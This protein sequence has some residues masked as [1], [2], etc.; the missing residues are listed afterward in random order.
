M[1]NARNPQ[2]RP[3]WRDAVFYEI[4]VRSFADANGDGVG[5][6]A[7]IR[8]RLDHLVDLGVDALWLTPFYPSPMA[9]HGYDV[10]D[11]RNVD[12]L[13]G[14]LTGFDAL[15]TDAHDKGL[16]L[17]VDVVPNHSSNAHPWF[18]Q[19]LAE[20]PRSAA[21]DRYLFRDGRGRKGSDPPNNWDSVFG[22]SAWT[23]VGDGQWYLHLFAPEQPDLNWRHPDV[24]ADYEQTLRFWLD[25]G[26]DGFRIDVAHGLFKDPAL[27]DAPGSSL[28][29]MADTFVPTPT[30]N[31]P[32]VHDV[33]R[34][35]RSICA[36]D[37]REPVL[38]GEV[39]IG[40]PSVVADYVRPDELHLAF[41]F[42]LL[43]ARWKPQLIRNAIE[44]SI[45]SLSTVGAPPTWVLANHDVVRQVT[46]YGGGESGARRAR[47]AI[48]LLLALPGPVFLYAGEELGLPEVELPPEALQDPVWERSGHTIPGRDGCRVPL[49]WSGERPPYGFAPP[50]TT[51][52][53]PMPD[54]WGAYTVAAEHSDQD[55]MLRLYADAL[56]QRRTQPALGDGALEWL[57]GPSDVLDFTRPDATRAIR[58]ILNMSAQAIDLPDQ[59]VLL[60]SGGLP[61][62]QLPP[63]S[64][65][66]LIA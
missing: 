4:Y 32:Q 56:R 15:V 8:A 40:D 61:D 23:Q 21:R 31:Q 11:P 29:L 64:A 16:R 20:G 5:D 54:D 3:W 58:C 22:G 26:V 51:T 60:S 47:A 25:H 35:W 41:N 17:I 59:E 65:V 48:L 39:W 6:L 10:A 38:V 13:F 1:P 63:D 9:D 50:G 24:A 33:Y 14:D 53:L 43:F 36:A 7:G 44:T 55:S 2:S 18:V 12:P 42:R 37:P 46:R 66:W 30:W 52:W 57:E 27:P 62:R 28:D 34:H 45:D 19:A 49:P